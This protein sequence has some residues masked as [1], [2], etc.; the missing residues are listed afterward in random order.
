MIL[1]LNGLCSV[2]KCEIDNSLHFLVMYFRSVVDYT[3]GE[4]L[5]WCAEETITGVQTKGGFSFYP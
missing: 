2:C 3:I 1:L 5:R 4:S